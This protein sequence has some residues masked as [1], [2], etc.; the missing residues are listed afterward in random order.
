MVPHGLR[1]HVFVF[2]VYRS[3]WVFSRVNYNSSI[4]PRGFDTFP[5]GPGLLNDYFI[6]RKEHWC[7][8]H[9]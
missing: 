3:I 2:Q 9:I 6:L 8:Y 1:V 4:D 5:H 7:N